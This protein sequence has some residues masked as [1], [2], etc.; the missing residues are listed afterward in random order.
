MNKET[1]FVC[2]DNSLEKY[3][4]EITEMNIIG[5]IK[6]FIKPKGETKKP[7][8]DKDSNKEV[9][10]TEIKE[11]EAGNGISPFL[12]NV[13]ANT[14]GGVL[15]VVV[16]AIIA[17]ITGIYNDIKSIPNLATKADISEMVTISDIENMVTTSD[18]ENMLR[19]T[20]RLYQRE[21]G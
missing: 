20:R 1:T 17:G 8:E 7:R 11:G 10:T 9:K 19:R 4:R 3:L 13:M 12:R 21:L 6:K 18:I 16:I 15:S 14:A 2:Y 5:K